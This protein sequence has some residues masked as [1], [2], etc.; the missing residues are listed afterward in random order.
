[1]KYLEKIDDFFSSSLE[2][3][4]VAPPVDAKKAIATELKKLSPK[5]NKKGGWLLL[6]ITSVSVIATAMYVSKSS[7]NKHQELTKVA[8][9]TI[10]KERLALNNTTII[11][12]QKQA[13]AVVINSTNAIQNSTP[14]VEKSL[15]NSL[16]TGHVYNARDINSTPNTTSSLS[17]QLTKTADATNNSSEENSAKATDEIE[18]H[19][20]VEERHSD[21]TSTADLMTETSSTQAEQVSANVNSENSILEE[22]VNANEETAVPENPLTQ[23][24]E[25][26]T[27]PVVKATHYY[28]LANA[29]MGVNSNHFYKSN[30]VAE[31]EL[32]D[33]M[34][35]N[36]PYLNVQLIAGIHKGSLGVATGI[37]IIKQTEKLQYSYIEQK[38][39]TILVDSIY[40]N[41][42]T[43]DT[44]ITH[45]VPV[46][47][48]MNYYKTNHV[49][50]VFTTLQLPLFFT[51]NYYFLRNWGV[52]VSVGGSVNF[53]L[54]SNGN[55]KTSP[56]G[57]L[58]EYTTKGNAPLKNVSFNAQA[59]L[60]LN[61]MFNQNSS[62][63]LSVPFQLGLSN[64]YKK[65]YFIDRSIN[66][67]GM[68]IGYK[69]TF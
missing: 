45:N 39:Q 26:P 65:E 4:E 19:K 32:K 14:D 20:P 38:S 24:K 2:N 15:V 66:T 47:T 1:M 30:V 60:G 58:S 34:V 7:N 13:E 49:Q 11:E 9:A 27:V 55:Y 48:L 59:M 22:Q 29:G 56:T 61:Y 17:Q 16:T 28:V 21:K 33:S 53:L 44:I 51:Y 64:I 35:F 6:A 37:N 62:L 18:A 42:V 57:S 41:P 43:H 52:D 67:T 12:E 54:G 10:S 50:T 8:K 63:L 69:Y 23:V 40:I 5:K 31:H 36:K 3:F 25:K 68:Q 46:D